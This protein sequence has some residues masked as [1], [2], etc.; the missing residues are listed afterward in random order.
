MTTSTLSN[1]ATV[2]KWTER[3]G[4]VADDVEVLAS[5]AHGDLE[6]FP[7]I[8]RRPVGGGGATYV[9]SDLD[10]AGIR[11]LI[12]E[13]GAGIPALR[14]DV[15]AAGGALEVIVRAGGDSE[16]TFLVNR[17]DDEVTSPLDGGIPL[18][19]AATGAS[20]VTIPPRGVVVTRSPRTKGSAA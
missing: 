11:M 13:L 14:G 3:V 10:P 18:T 17:T 5:Y 4:S 6:G 12:D 15:R 8:T 2:T 20:A 19:D 1:G 7:A 9:A 16:Y